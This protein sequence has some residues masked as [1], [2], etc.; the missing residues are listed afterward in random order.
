MSNAIPTIIMAIIMAA[1]LLVFLEVNVVL[2]NQLILWCE[3]SHTV[4]RDGVEWRRV[5]SL[6]WGAFGI[7]SMSYIGPT[8]YKNFH[9]KCLLY[10]AACSIATR[11]AHT[12]ITINHWRNT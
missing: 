8:E 3:M 9:Y 12:G 11:S 4:I 6:R 1:S 7:T 10:P 5:G 2:W